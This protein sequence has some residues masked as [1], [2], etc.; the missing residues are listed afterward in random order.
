M[1]DPGDIGTATLTPVKCEIL[2]IYVCTDKELVDKDN[3]L[4][5]ENFIYYCRSSRDFN[6]A[7]TEA[8]GQPAD[9]TEGEGEEEEEEEE[10][11]R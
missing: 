10:V 8:E 6:E 3:E 1:P 4:Q 2:H 5:R 7:V 11:A 9:A